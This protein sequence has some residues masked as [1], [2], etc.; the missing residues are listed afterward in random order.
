MEP[1]RITQKDGRTYAEGSFLELG[2]NKNGRVYKMSNV[3]EK[4]EELKKEIRNGNLLGELEHPDRFEVS[5]GNV[6]HIIQDLWM[7]EDRGQLC[8]RAEI[9]EG[10]PKGR[11]VKALAEQKIPFYMGMRAA[12]V[13]NDDKTVDID[14]IYS[15]DLLKEPPHELLTEFRRKTDTTEK[16]D[17]MYNIFSEYQN[18]LPQ[19]H[20]PPP[21]PPPMPKDVSRRELL[22]FA[23]YIPIGSM[24]EAKA[25]SRLAEM[26]HNIDREFKEVQEYTNYLIKTFVFASKADEVK[27]ECVFPKNQDNIDLSGIFETIENSDPTKEYKGFTVDDERV[28]TDRKDRRTYT[29]ENM[30]KLNSEQFRSIMEN[31]TII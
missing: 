4:V 18:S 6:S 2:R 9:L 29:K 26:K 7:D 27:M 5:L 3:I 22:I 14:K 21:P 1:L 28:F 30:E 16:G 15:F 20:N 12:G 17:P 31:R 24:S 19:F 8:G 13:I 11:I 23:I 10:S 25:R